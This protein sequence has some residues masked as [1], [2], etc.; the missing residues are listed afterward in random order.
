MMVRAMRR[1]TERR[2]ETETMRSSVRSSVW[3]AAICANCSQQRARVDRGQTGGEA[4]RW[5]CVHMPA[6]ALSPA[7][8]WF[9]RLQA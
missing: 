9:S 5:L 4:T 3:M 2:N 7:I 8:K 1:E 6:Q